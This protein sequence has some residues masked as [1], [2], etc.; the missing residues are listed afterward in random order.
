MGHTLS[1]LSA[2]VRGWHEHTQM[3]RVCR[4]DTGAH[5]P[6]H[7][8]TLSRRCVCP[9]QGVPNFKLADS[10]TNTLI[11]EIIELLNKQ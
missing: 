4:V 1:P 6:A 8:H 7:R 9:G 10:L 11:H 5:A 2:V 3:S